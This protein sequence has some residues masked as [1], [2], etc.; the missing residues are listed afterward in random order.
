MRHKGAGAGEAH[1]VHMVKSSGDA[2]NTSM[3]DLNLGEK[4]S[5]WPEPNGEL[6]KVQNRTY[7]RESHWARFARNFEGMINGLVNG[8]LR[9]FCICTRGYT[10]KLIQRSFLIGW[11]LTRRFDLELRRG[12]SSV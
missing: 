6:K 2:I 12:E 8:K 3:K 7:L 10:Q 9:P 4:S 5:T 1:E 11:L